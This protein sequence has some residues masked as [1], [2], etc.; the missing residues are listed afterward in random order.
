MSFTAHIRLDHTNDPRLY[1]VALQSI[2]VYRIN[3]T[4]KG[5]RKTKP[6]GW[7]SHD[8]FY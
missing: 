2:I 3:N 1:P 4:F 6:A 5:L 8:Q 7:T